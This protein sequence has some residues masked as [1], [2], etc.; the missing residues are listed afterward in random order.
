M[1]FE[2]T[3]EE[4]REIARLVAQ[5]PK[6]DF[7]LLPVLHLAQKKFGHLSPDAQI[8]VADTLAVPPTRVREV[9]T[10]YEMFHEH[11]GAQVHLELC[12]NI[13]CHLLGADALMD[14]LK[15]RLGVEVGHQTEDGVFEL[16]ETECLASCGSGPC[17]KVGNDYYEHLTPEAIDTLLPRLREA[18]KKLN[19]RNYYEGER[20]P[21]VGPVPG[22]APRRPAAAEGAPASP[23]P[24]SAISASKS[25]GHA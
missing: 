19:G 10:F 16:V 25:D 15:R 23:D 11:A 18:A 3:E 8:L 2:W 17:M 22:V 21:H 5:Y 12:T 9:V 4:A 20:G 13:S 7:A 24:I 1:P 14:H 6:K